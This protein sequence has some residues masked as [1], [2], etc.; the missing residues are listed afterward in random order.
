MPGFDPADTLWSGLAVPIGLAFFFRSSAEDKM[1]AVYPSP[2]GP[3]PASVDAGAWQRVLDQ[4]PALAL[5]ESDVQAL[6]V[7][8]IDGARDAFIVP[9]DL[10]Y[11]LVGRLRLKWRGISGGEAVR[12][13]L[14]QYFR[15]MRERAA[16]FRKEAPHA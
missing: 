1:V 10:C 11:E 3:T 9:M 15:L 13:E 6:L 8:R 5:M 7:H 14:A 4:N 12:S 16:P 2:A